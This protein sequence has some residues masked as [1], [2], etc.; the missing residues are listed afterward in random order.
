MV[1]T[2]VDVKVD[3]FL[4]KVNKRCQ[5][6]LPALADKF[7]R[8]TCNFDDTCRL[9]YLWALVEIARKRKYLYFHNFSPDFQQSDAFTFSRL[10][11]DNFKVSYF[12]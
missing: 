10:L 8:V 2:S 6:K 9:N 5:V 1:F 11:Y 7:V 3:K 4:D 12:D